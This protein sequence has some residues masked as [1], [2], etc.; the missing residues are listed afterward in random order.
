MDAHAETQTLSVEARSV[1]EREYLVRIAPS[2]SARGNQTGSILTLVDV[3]PLRESE[4]RR[5]EA[6]RFLS[7]D[8]RS[9]QA[10]ILTLLEMYHGDPQ[11]MPAE[12][13]TERVGRYAPDLDRR[14]I[15]AAAKAERVDARNFEQDLANCYAMPRRMPGRTPRPE[16]FVLISTLRSM[17][18]GCWAIGTCSCVR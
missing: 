6:L 16:T 18:P 4:R 7:H 17:T 2:F 1:D 8:M 12:K 10:S 11:S 14:T 3:T 5:D 15:F 13:L 9:P